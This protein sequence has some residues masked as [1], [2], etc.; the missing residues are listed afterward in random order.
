MVKIAYIGAG[1]LQFGPIIVQDILMSTT[2]CQNGLEIHLMDIEKN[3]L[4]H[5][6]KHG[7][8]VNEKLNRQAKII[9]TTDRDEAIKGADFV[10]CALEKDRNVYWAQD[11]HIPRKYGFKQVYGENGGVG[12]LFHAL[13]NIKVIMDLA[14]AMETLCPKALLLNFSNPEH[15]ICEAVTRL[16]SIKA[17]GL[18][19]GVF[20]GR[21]QLSELLDVPLNDLQTKAC[22]INHFTWFQEIAQKSTGEDLYPKLREVEKKGDWL[23][24]WHELALGRILFRRFGQWPSPASNHYGEYIRWAEEFVIPQLQFFYDPTEGH[25]WENNQIPE[26]VYTVDRVDY[27]REWIK[28]WS[29]KLLPVGSTEEIQLENEDGSF[30]SSGEIATQIMESVVSNEKQW[31]EAVNV[32]NKGAIPNLPDD[33]VVELPAYCDAEGIQPISMEP[34]PEG[35]AATI[36][37]HASIHQLL[38]EAYNEQSKDKLLQAILIEPTVN[39]YRN[40]VDMCNEMLTLQKEVLPL[41]N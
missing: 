8:Y 16:T 25:P 30:K 39:S 20:M 1:S 14:R 34:I 15:K 9:A 7:E 11:F 6:V 4:K 36:R 41:L 40:A 37:L 35:I 31:L 23:A 32:P 10:I 13:R 3:H 27:E 5:V 26:G 22:G 2:L 18:C 24:K 29:K 38:V 19:H 28:D 33:L 12:S 17:V 21:E